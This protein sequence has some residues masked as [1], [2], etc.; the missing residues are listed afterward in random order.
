MEKTKRRLLRNIITIVVAIVF[1]ILYR[2]SF[3]IPGIVENIYSRG[4]F[5]FVNQLL[6]SFTGLV[7]ISLG[8]LT[9]YVFIVFIVIYLIYII[10]SVIIVP[11]KRLYRLFCRTMT[12]LAIAAN[13]FTTFV[14]LWGFNYARQPLS[15]NMQLEVKPVEK[16]VL[17][18][19]CEYLVNEANALRKDVAENS[20]GIFIS[21]YKK[22]DILE[23]IPEVLNKTA[24][25]LHMDYLSG[26]FGRVKPVLYS[27]GM[28]YAGLVGI[29]Y[30]FT[31]EANVNMDIPMLTFIA[32]AFH[33]AAHQR[34]IAREDEANF[35]AYYLSR[36]SGDKDFAYSGTI[37]ALLYAVESLQNTDRD[38]ARN[39][40]S[41]FSDAVKRDIADYQ[42]YWE[43]FE[44]P[45]DKAVEAM[46][47]TYLKAN[48]QAEGVKSYGRMVDLMIALY[49]KEYKKPVITEV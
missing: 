1:Y 43:S 21:R 18:D 37:L 26:S 20:Q 28:S 44:G 7:H 13:I 29:F 3:L 35:I 11:G 49:T 4:F 15:V 24:Q 45:M 10:L 22:E 34:G 8:E 25:K 42:S 16:E 14:V 38:M 9:L 39:I 33:E 2:F 27:K 40:R 32:G 12:L 6:S 47:N 31:G 41:L 30:P 23:K 19:L 5:K 17:Y 46:N 48:N 36:E